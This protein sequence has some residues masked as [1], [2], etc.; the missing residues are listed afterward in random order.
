MRIATLPWR[1]P[2]AREE[3]GVL[4]LPWIVVSHTIPK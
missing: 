3:G 2:A 1:L 4:V